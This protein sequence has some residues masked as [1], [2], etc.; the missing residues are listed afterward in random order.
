LRV[1]T[2][3]EVAKAAGLR[4]AWSDKHPAYDLVNGP[5][6]HG[7][8]DLYTPEIAATKQPDGRT[9]L[10]ADCLSGDSSVTDTIQYDTFKV[11]AI[12]NEIAGKDHSGTTTVGVPVIFGMNFQALSVAQKSATGGYLDA[13]ATPSREVR[14]ALAFV[15]ASLGEMVAALKTHG[16]AASTLIIV[17]AK[18]GQAPI[19]RR[20]LQKIGH[21]VPAIVNGV[22]PK[23]VA[24]A[25]E[26]DVSLLWLSDQS[27]TAAAVAALQ[28]DEAGANTAHI[29]T[30]LAG[31]TLQ[32]HFGSP[33]TDP[34]VPDIIV[35]PKLGVIYTTPT[36]S[37]IA[38][39][40]GFSR[41]DTKVALLIS[42][43]GLEAT[44]EGEAVQTTQI[45]PTILKAL[46]LKPQALQ[47]VRREH[48]HV[49]PGLT[50][51]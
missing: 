44:T 1:N 29:R 50:L 30:I 11:H 49:L 15:D 24:Q 27:K 8:D 16:L 21:P 7:V 36:A 13:K 10:Y 34:R 2:I 31:S 3:F 42:N 33:R 23:L 5:S 20:L 4:T 35:L 14:T 32:T 41:D 48:T 12:L 38:E 22:Q 37:K 46:G 26:D 19:D 6:G 45:A 28:A 9:C 18:H 39:H 25:T 17:T 40:G 51:G 43:P 47:A